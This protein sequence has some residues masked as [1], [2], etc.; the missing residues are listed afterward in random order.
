MI[1]KKKI[2]CGSHGS[3]R[4]ERS[5]VDEPEPEDG[6]DL[7][8]TSLLRAVTLAISEKLSSCEIQPRCLTDSPSCLRQVA[9][10]RRDVATTTTSDVISRYG[11]S[12]RDGLVDAWRF[13]IPVSFVSLST[14]STKLRRPVLSP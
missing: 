11:E 14:L 7:S 2:C 4:S 6:C 5:G 10:R 13:F 3:A 12:V 1:L 8:R 9:T